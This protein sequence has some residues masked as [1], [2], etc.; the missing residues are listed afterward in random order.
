M[1]SKLIALTVVVCGL[2]AL[3]LC[4]AMPGAAASPTHRPAG[5]VTLA[6]DNPIPN[7]TPAGA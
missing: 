1:R 2:L 7:T 6:D 4:Q 5:A 3:V